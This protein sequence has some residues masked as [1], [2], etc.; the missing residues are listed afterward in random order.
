MAW[1][2]TTP[3]HGAMAGNGF[4]LNGVETSDASACEILKAA[5]AAGLSIFIDQLTVSIDTARTV[6]IGEG[7]AVAG[8]LDTALIGPVPFAANQTI[9]WDFSRVGGMKLTAATLLAVDTS[10]AGALCVFIT[11]RVE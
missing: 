1:T 5:P 4:I 3:E 7:E 10:G 2:V 9:K 8:T 6:T 11:G